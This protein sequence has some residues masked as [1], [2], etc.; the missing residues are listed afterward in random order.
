M[1]TSLTTRGLL[2]LTAVALSLT[3]MA[4]VPAEGRAEARSRGSMMLK[5]HDADGDGTIA[6]QEF[7]AGGDEMF[8]RLDADGDGRLSADELAAARSWRHPDRGE[9]GNDAQRDDKRA[10]QRGQRGFQRMDADG[11]GFVGRDEFDAARL[12]RFNR[13]DANGNGIIDAD[14]LPQRKGGRKGHGK[15]DCQRGTDSAR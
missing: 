1:T 3:A 4:E 9:R 7:K 15:R 12:A 2:A 5:H 11:D 6:L 14:E 8:A 10:G 13:L